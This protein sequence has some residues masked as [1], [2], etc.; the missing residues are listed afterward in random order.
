MLVAF[1]RHLFLAAQINVAS[2]SS[3][4]LALYGGI[5]GQFRCPKADAGSYVCNVGFLQGVAVHL[6]LQIETATVRTHVARSRQTPA[7]QT[8]KRC[9]TSFCGLT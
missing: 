6:Q 8:S 3:S 1:K 9:L 2:K 7:V 4:P 5:E